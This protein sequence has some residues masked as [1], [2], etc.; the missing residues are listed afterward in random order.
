MNGI[1]I[2]QHHL[3]KMYLYYVNFGP[4]ERIL[5]FVD[6]GPQQGATFN[7]VVVLG[8]V[9]LFFIQIAYGDT[10]HQRLKLS[11]I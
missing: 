5:N 7:A 10:V 2:Y 11:S 8:V 1:M 9:S 3:S 6:N 4:K